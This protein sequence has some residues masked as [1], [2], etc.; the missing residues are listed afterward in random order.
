MNVCEQVGKIDTADQIDTAA[1]GMFYQYYYLQFLV[2][3]KLGMLN[4]FF[5]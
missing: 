5:F 2:S 1:S 4:S 3:K